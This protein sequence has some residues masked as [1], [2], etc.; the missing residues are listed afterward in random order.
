MSHQLQVHYRTSQTLQINEEC[1]EVHHQFEC[2]RNCILE[3]VTNIQGRI[4]LHKHSMHPPQ[5]SHLGIAC[6]SYE[7]SN[8]STAVLKRRI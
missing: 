7:W 5:F 6:R 2:Y 1:E 8:G 4:Y 3:A